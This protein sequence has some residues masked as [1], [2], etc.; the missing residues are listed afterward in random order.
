MRMRALLYLMK[1]RVRDRAVKRPDDGLSCRAGMDLIA[2]VIVWG[3][4]LA[5]GLAL[6]RVAARRDAWDFAMSTGA[7]RAWLAVEELSSI[8]SPSGRPFFAS[9]AARR[10]LTV[11]LADDIL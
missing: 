4:V 1:Q 11:L 9:P 8:S 7:D 3:V 6:C 5:P 2:V 10:E